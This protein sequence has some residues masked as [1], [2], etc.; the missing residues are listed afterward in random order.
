MNTL[1]ETVRSILDR[2][3]SSEDAASDLFE[4]LRAALEQPKQEQHQPWCDSATKLLLSNPPQIPPCN[5]KQ[6]PVTQ[7]EQE[8]VALIRDGVL[9]WHIPNEHYSRP[10]WTAHGTHMLYAQPPQCK[11]LTEKEIEDI[12][13]ATDAPILGATYIKLV[14]QIEAAHGIKEKP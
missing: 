1:K 10:A 5:C 14:R 3:D 2:W 13:V 6:E 12:W 4:E 9:C 7:S 8:P 11:P